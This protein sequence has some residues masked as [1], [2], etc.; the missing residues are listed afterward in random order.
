MAIKATVYRW[1]NWGGD[2][3]PKALW[4]RL[5]NQLLPHLQNDYLV[6]DGLFRALAIYNGK[7]E[8]QGWCHFPTLKARFIHHESDCYVELSLRGCFCPG[9][10]ALRSVASSDLPDNLQGW[11]RS[12][13]S[14]SVATHV[15]AVRDFVTRC[16]QAGIEL[17]EVSF[18]SDV[19]SPTFTTGAGDISGK[20]LSVFSSLVSPL[21]AAVSKSLIVH[22]YY[23]DSAGSF[24]RS[25]RDAHR[26]ILGEQGFIDEVSIAGFN[27]ESFQRDCLHILLVPGA[28]DFV[29]D[30]SWQ[31]LLYRLER[32]QIAFK[33][34]KASNAHDRFVVRNLIFD[35]YV[36]AGGVPWAARFKDQRLV[37]A[38]DAGHSSE[39]SLSRWVGCRYSKKDQR[40]RLY[41]QDC[42]LAE[43]VPENIADKL[44][45]KLSSENSLILRDGR[46]HKSDAEFTRRAGLDVIA[47]NKRPTAVI[48][49]EAG[50]Q[51]RVVPKGTYLEYPDG[52]VLLQS[53]IGSAT[54]DYVRPIQLSSRS[55][56]LSSAVLSDIQALV[57]L[58][59]LSS[60]HSIRLPL[61][62][63]WADLASK[64]NSSDWVRVLGNGWKLEGLVP[65]LRAG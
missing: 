15:T 46:M 24:V 41:Y 61:P 57:E 44:L 50:D 2:P 16:N 55:M 60:M 49:E 45:A 28:S 39:L 42:G 53:A 64:L 18:K 48:Y 51:I 58:P 22:T 35:L 11:V 52:S 62:V 4:E 1:R 3:R 6:I 23:P 65:A 5:K 36:K 9:E 56:A 43:Q 19:A 37:C 26:Q 25:L 13:S 20:D 38:L 33:V 14:K 30:V 17:E 34:V 7:Q 63:Y 12:V 54:K 21:R 59:S 29:K 47:I 8:R 40:Q 27:K 31:R 32:S 10:Q